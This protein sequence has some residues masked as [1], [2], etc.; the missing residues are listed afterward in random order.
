LPAPSPKPTPAY[1]SCLTFFAV[2]TSIAGKLVAV[3]TITGVALASD[4][5]GVALSDVSL[6]DVSFVASSIGAAP[7][8]ALAVTGATA[9]P[10]HPITTQRARATPQHNGS[11]AR[12]TIPA[13][14]CQPPLPSCPISPMRPASRSRSRLAILA[15]LAVAVAL[16]TPEVRAATPTPRATADS[17]RMYAVTL[18]NL[19][20][21]D[22]GAGYLHAF[23]RTL[24]TAGPDTPARLQWGRGCPDVSDRTFIALTTAFSNPERF[25]LIVDRSPDPRQP[26]AYC[27]TNVE[28]ERIQP[29]QDPPRPAGPAQITHPSTSPSTEAP[30][31]LLKK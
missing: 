20:V 14:A 12:P 13:T 8:R 11:A 19:V 15:V 1:Q 26:S 17:K 23:W 18:T 10:A 28:L 27:V 21:W 5:D 16:A 4:G 2:V 22:N 24:G 7:S 29:P 30:P 9:T 31:P 25:I 3:D 6:S